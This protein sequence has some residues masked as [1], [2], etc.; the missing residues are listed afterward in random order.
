MDV[1]LIREYLSAK[2]GRLVAQRMTDRIVAAVGQL[3]TMPRI[4]RPGLRSGTRELTS[5]PPYV[6]VYRVRG[7]D[8][9]VSDSPGDVEILRIWHGAQDRPHGDPPPG[10]IGH[11]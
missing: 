5:V 2:A 4:G 8:G 6:I 3:G 10:M 1:I 11:P 9:S 7:D